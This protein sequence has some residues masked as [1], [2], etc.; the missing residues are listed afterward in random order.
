MKSS[1]TYNC[2]LR[3]IGQSLESQRINV[4]ELRTED[5]RFIVKGDPEKETSLL[6]ALR[7]WQKRRRREGLNSSLS[8]ALA[9]IEQLERQGKGKRLRPNRLPDFYSLPNVLRTVGAYL[10][11]KAADL[12]ELHMAPLTVTL[13]YRNRNGHPGFEERSIASFYDFFLQLHGRRRTAEADS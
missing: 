11:A 7:E 1:E 9:D 13:L 10:D 8:F 2:Q 5:E 3:N 6:N 12:I 4:F